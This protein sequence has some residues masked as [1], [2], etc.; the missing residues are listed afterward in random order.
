MKAANR[1]KYLKKLALLCSMGLLLPVL[2]GFGAI[3]ST[4]ARAS[5]APVLTLEAE[6]GKLGGNA[7]ISGQKVGNI[8]KNG[9]SVEGK[10]TFDKLALPADGEYLLRLHYYSGSTD[11]YFNLTTDF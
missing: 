10:V 6:Q 8:G 9:G 5:D 11:R 3:A 1:K 7:S 2:G 4:D